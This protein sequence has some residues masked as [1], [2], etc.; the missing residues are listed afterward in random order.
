MT[1]KDVALWLIAIAIL[2][3]ICVVGE[4]INKHDEQHI[5]ESMDY[6]KTIESINQRMDKLMETEQTT[7]ETVIIEDEPL[8]TLWDGATSPLEAVV[9]TSTSQVME[10]VGVFTVS[11]FC[12]CKLC[13]G[14]TDGITASGAKVQE[15]LTIA[16][17]LSVFPF[18]TVLYLEGIG[19]R[20]V[21]DT[22]N[23]KGNKLDLYMSSHKTALAF[24]RQNIKVYVVK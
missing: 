13:C 2:F 22:G 15:G 12:S 1:R 18:G 4:R 8:G 20:E 5:T 6:A 7:I 23:F 11:A 19:E 10:Y 17:D 24:G 3:L 9:T 16:A 21:Q 14:K